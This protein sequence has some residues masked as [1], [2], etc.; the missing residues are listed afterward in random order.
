[1]LFRSFLTA[2]GVLVGTLWLHALGVLLFAVAATHAAVRARTE[3]WLLLGYWL[4]LAV[5]LQQ[6]LGHGGEMHRDVT[7]ASW[8]A[9]VL[10]WLVPLVY[11]LSGSVAR[12]AREP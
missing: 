7:T 3:F 6:L 2:F 10:A 11:L 8:V 4:A 5:T 9:T 12:P 1:M